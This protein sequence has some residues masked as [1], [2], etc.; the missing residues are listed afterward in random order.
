MGQ[1]RVDDRSLVKSLP[2]REREIG[3]SR[4]LIS[5]TVEF[6]LTCLSFRMRF[7]IATI[8]KGF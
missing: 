8:L 4:G 2:S 1:L 7:I 6:E 3:I 5:G